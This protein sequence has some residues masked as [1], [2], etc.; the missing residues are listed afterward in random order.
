VGDPGRHHRHSLSAP[1]PLSDLFL[2]FVLSCVGNTAVNALARRFRY[3]KLNVV[4]VYAAFLAILAGVIV[5]VCRECSTW[6]SLKSGSSRS[7][8]GY[9]DPPDRTR[10]TLDKRV[11]SRIL[12]SSG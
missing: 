5:L 3:R 6:V 4:V 9:G 10:E 2:T 11:I 8:S 7:P 1:S 12:G